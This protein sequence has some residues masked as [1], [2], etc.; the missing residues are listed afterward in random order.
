MNSGAAFNG[1]DL[2]SETATVTA[3]AGGEVEI[4]ASKTIN[5]KTRAGGNIAVYGSPKFK[6]TKNVI[7]GEIVFK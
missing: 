4:F 6:N 3:N 5:A 7:G 2:E 1:K